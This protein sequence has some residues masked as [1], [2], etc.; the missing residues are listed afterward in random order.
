VR[1]FPRA[2]QAIDTHSVL[3][4]ANPDLTSLVPKKDKLLSEKKFETGAETAGQSFFLVRLTLQEANTPS[5]NLVLGLLVTIVRKGAAIM[6][7]Q[8]QSEWMKKDWRSWTAGFL[9]LLWLVSGF[10]VG[11]KL[12]QP[13]SVPVISRATAETP[14]LPEFA[15]PDDIGGV[16]P[17]A[18]PRPLSEADA[19]FERLLLGTPTGVQKQPVLAHAAPENRSG[20]VARALPGKLVSLDNQTENELLLALRGMPDVG[21]KSSRVGTLLQ[22]ETLEQRAN[23]SAVAPSVFESGLQ[24]S[25]ER[26]RLMKIIGLRL[27][28]SMRIDSGSAKVRGTLAYGSD[29][30]APE[31]APAYL[32]IMQAKD[33]ESRRKLVTTLA[34]IDGPA[35]TAG[36]AHRA[37]F[38][39]S[40]QIRQDALGSLRQ[41]PA[42]QYR[43]ALLDA[44]RYPWPPVAEHAA[45][46]LVTLRP[47]RILP[48]LEELLTR[49]DPCAPF[50][51]SSGK[52]RVPAIV[53]VK[54][55]S[56]CF[57]CH[58]GARPEDEFRASVPVPGQPIIDTTYYDHGGTFVRPDQVLLRPDFSVSLPVP[59]E[60]PWPDQ[61]RFDFLVGFRPL[62][63]REESEA[64]R[65]LAAGSGTQDYP[66][67]RAVQFAIRE[68][69][70]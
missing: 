55:L 65:N 39:P 43:Q 17:G 44:L 23:I 37:L 38:D 15:D 12:C 11:K 16:Q 10:F 68:L 58:P 6:A 46:A 64:L 29:P 21:A 57:L 52:W 18:E 27:R 50:Q 51:D 60:K 7:L 40:R 33:P 31:S 28:G 1:G 32:Q 54:H 8:A 66:Q 5:P 4:A 56:N 3:V 49:P 47:S 19:A 36:L 35:A 9:I 34:R 13:P 41:R 63:E 2:G 24:N 30:T 14:F 67:R 70:K 25:Y 59:N 48:L 20:A 62:T 53:K 45:E 69:S 61:Q 22:T 26:A 42:D